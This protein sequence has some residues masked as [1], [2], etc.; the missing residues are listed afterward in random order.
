[1]RIVLDIGSATFIYTKAKRPKLETKLFENNEKLNFDSTIKAVE[2][3]G[4]FC[5]KKRLSFA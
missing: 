1:M 3:Y 4:I 5:K 2:T